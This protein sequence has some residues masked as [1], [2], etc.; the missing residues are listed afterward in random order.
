MKAIGF[1][2]HLPIANK[3]SLIEFEIPT[4]KA[5]GHDLLVKVNAVSVNP[6]DVGVRK[7]GHG[8]L[9]QPKVIGWDAVGIV[10]ETGSKVTLFNKGDRVFY[11]GSFI[12]P[13]S[14]SQYQLVDERIVG[15]A[16]SKLPDAKIAAMP[17]TSL[18]AWEALFEQLAINPTAKELNHSKNILIINGSGGVG[19]VA[20]Q[21]AHWAGLNVI[22]SASRP[23]TIKWVQEHGANQTVNHRNDLVT[24]IR[25]LGYK[26][27]DYILELNDLDGHWNEMVEL[28]KPS[29]HIASITENR[30]PIDLKKLT[31]KR[32]I[33][34]WEWM[35]SKSYYQTSDMITQHEI[36]NQISKLLDEGIIKST[37]A[38]ELSPITVDNLKKAHQLVETNH[39]IGKVVVSN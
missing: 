16:P 20:T 36:L 29:G 32:A 13:G 18:T 25:N 10:E 15:S 24:E 2:E 23:E 34:A 7:G 6:V 38:Q 12:R 17:L 3:N 27:V 19:S 1:K 22:A 14:D 37:L 8:T 33:F 28:I 5:E 11:A 26:Y 30:H 31:T 21:L 39:M 9:K 35:Y 4:P